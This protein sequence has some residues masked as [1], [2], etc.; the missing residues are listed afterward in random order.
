MAL[1]DA[2]TRRELR[3]GLCE[4]QR[5]VCCYCNKRITPQDLIVEHW[6]PQSEDRLRRLDWNNLLAACSGVTGSDR[7]CDGSKANQ[8]ISLN[9]KNR[10]HIESLRYT[11]GGKLKSSRGE[12]DQ[13]LNNVLNLN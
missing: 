12:H 1:L 4:N 9:P 8:P 2:E 10:Q 7:H 5:E 6:S 3:L 13:E 11:T